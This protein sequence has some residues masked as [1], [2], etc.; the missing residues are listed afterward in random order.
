VDTEEAEGDNGVRNDD[1]EDIRMGLDRNT[2][3]RFRKFGYLT[4]ACFFCLLVASQLAF[5]QVDEGSITGTVQ[6]ATGAVV[7]GAQVTLLNTDQ[8]ITLQTRTSN[9]GEYTFSPVRIGHYTVTVTAKGFAKT[10]QK[11]LEVNVAQSLQVNVQLKLGAATETVEVSTAP[12]LMQTEEASVGQVVNEESVSSLPLNGRNFTFL[13]QLGAGMQTPQADTRGNA[14]SGAFSANGLRPAQNNY[15]LDGIDNNSNAVD[16]LNGTNFVVLPPVD[17][18]SEFKVQTADFSAELGRSAGAVM[19]ATI[20]TGTNSFH[21]SAWE[22]FRNRVLDAAD[23]FEDNNADPTLRVKGALQQ[24]QF[25]FTAGGPIVKNK[26]FLF[27]DFESL[28]RVLGSP[29]TAAV[30]S[31]LEAGSGFT[32]LSEILAADSGTITDNLGR[33]ILQGTVLDPATTRYVTAGT[34]DPVSGIAATTTGYVRDPFNCAASVAAPTL[35]TCPNLNQLP[36]GRLDPNAI[37]LLQTYPSASTSNVAKLFSNFESSPNIFEHRNALDYRADFDASDKDQL[38]YRFSYVDDPQYIP[39]PFGG[40]ADGG[41]FEQGIQTAKSNQSAAA[42]TH[43][44]SPNTVNVG[45]V[46]YNHLHTTRY[47]PEGGV[48]GVPGQFGIQGIPQSAENGGLPEYDIGG[49]TDLGSNSFL[50]S[51]EIS[52]TLQLTDDFTHIWGK[53]SFKMGIESQHIKF[54]TLQPAYSRGNFDYNG[55]FAAVP[56]QNAGNLG[57][58]QFLLTPEAATVANGVDYSGGSDSI[59]ASNISTTDDYKTYTALYLQD[60]WKLGPKLTIN[61][62]IRWDYFGPIQETNGGQANFVPSALGAPTYLIPATGKDNRTLSSTANTPSLAGDGFIDLLAKDGI[63]LDETNK[64]GRGLMQN[65]KTNFSPRV[66]FAYQFGPKLVVRGGFGLFYNSFENQGYGPNIGENYPFV[67]N[68]SYGP[69]SSSS[70]TGATDGVAPIGYGTPWAGYSTASA[71]GTYTLESGLSCIAFTPA[72]VNADGLGLQGLQFNF[73][74]PRTLSTN[75]TL[76]YSVTRTLSAT[77]SYVFTQG[78]NLQTGTGTNQVSQIYSATQSTSDTIASGKNEVPWPDFSQGMSYHQTIGGSDYNGLQTKLEWQNAYGLNFLAAY[79][80]SKTTG[81]AGDLLNG[82]S[83]GG[84][85][86]PSVPGLGPS[87]DWGLADFDLRNVVHFSGGYEL[88]FGKDKQ[89]LNA[90][91]A[92]NAVIGGWSAW[93]I[94]TL[95]GGQPINFGCAE[96]T[97]AGLGCNTVLVAGQS[98]KLGLH[99]D[100]AGG[101]HWIGNPGAFNQPCQLQL[102][103]DGTLGAGTSPTPTGCIPET[104]SAALGGRPG[105]IPGPGLHKFDFSMFKLIPFNERISM[106]FRA[107]FFN[108]LNHPNFNAPN[109]SGNGVNGI[110]NSGTYTSSTFGEIGSTRD[111]PYDPREIQ[112]ALKLAF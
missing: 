57:L 64:Y 77:A 106:Q 48:S 97:A 35:N 103:P 72:V 42:W 100:T 76:Q 56:N 39:G 43:V 22:F 17:A 14:A 90:G 82:G 86:A 30:P 94:V 93:W 91:K 1:S 95:Q 110:S 81:D 41:G 20:K 25:G 54:D 58:A 112:F 45:R 27:G 88:P 111:N 84:Y 107:D 98:P 7:P 34:V 18:I 99:E 61:L 52:Q 19:N 21:G 38:F 66:G 83:T 102:L 47:G 10:T 89:W 3:A 9:S 69:K 2:F 74:T 85:R 60:D 36:A 55:Q 104:G 23:W 11:N 78:T 96:G 29:Q 40:V 46:G 49:L 63:T 37:A 71:G 68:F 12:P 67:Y 44:F 62:G 6:D 4:L 15:L 109:F 79:T 108:I 28:H 13:A 26:I 5:S 33:T 50:P 32:N 8:G 92:T 16:F 80:Y 87:F 53:H 75:F 65:Q 24:N 73:Q 105:Q 59:N 101:L 31:A 51:D 70:N